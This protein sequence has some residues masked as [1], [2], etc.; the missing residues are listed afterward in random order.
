MLSDKYVRAL[1]RAEKK[2]KSQQNAEDYRRFKKHIRASSRITIPLTNLKNIKTAI[3]MLGLL[4]E[5]LG[6]L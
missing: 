2:S 4:T 5:E 3:E 1:I 6:L